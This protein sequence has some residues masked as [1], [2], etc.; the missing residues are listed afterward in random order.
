MSLRK[1]QRG[2]SR[3]CVKCGRRAW[4]HGKETG[5]KCEDPNCGKD[6]MAEWKLKKSTQK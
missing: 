6:V 4:Y 3:P 5:W 2:V 1:L